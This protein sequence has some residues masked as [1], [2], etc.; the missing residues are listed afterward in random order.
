MN[1]SLQDDSKLDAHAY[2]MQNV[3]TQKSHSVYD[4]HRSSVNE[5]SI[6]NKLSALRNVF[7]QIRQNLDESSMTGTKT[8]GQQSVSIEQS[9]VQQAQNNY[10]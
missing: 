3:S 4:H 9:I 8:A 10:C 1:S 6:H 7:S 5:S 2:A